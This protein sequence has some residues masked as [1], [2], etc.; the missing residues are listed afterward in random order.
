VFDGQTEI[1]DEDEFMH[2]DTLV[3]HSEW[4]KEGSM[5]W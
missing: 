1:K 5:P 4:D 2:G 3:T